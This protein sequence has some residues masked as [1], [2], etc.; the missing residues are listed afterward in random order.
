MTTKSNDFQFFRG[1]DIDRQRVRTGEHWYAADV[2]WTRSG[3]GPQPARIWRRHP[4]MRRRIYRLENAP[5][6]RRSAIWDGYVNCWPSFGGVT[7]NTWWPQP[8]HQTLTLFWQV[9]SSPLPPLRLGRAARNFKAY[10]TS[11]KWEERALEHSPSAI[12]TW[13]APTDPSQLACQ[14]GSTTPR[15]CW[16]GG[17]L[18]TKTLGRFKALGQG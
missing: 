1:K 14:C 12:Y 5:C 6:R 16:P 10:R 3:M 17:Q 2:S 4:F 11:S 9:P 15:T 7:S 13:W 18:P 8:V